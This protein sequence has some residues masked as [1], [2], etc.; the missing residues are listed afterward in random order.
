MP[1]TYPTL[2]FLE[3]KILWSLAAWRNV[4]MG[5][6]LKVF[7]ISAFF[8]A[9]MGV[10]QPY[11]AEWYES[12]ESSGIDQSRSVWKNIS[13]SGS[14]TGSQNVQ[15]AV[16]EI[17]ESVSREAAQIAE[18]AS[19]MEQD[20]FHATESKGVTATASAGDGGCETQVTPS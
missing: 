8:F 14:V 20:A 3:A 4:A 11:A 18:S 10:I 19:A 16:A 1:L 12:M 9:S 7:I 17:S 13:T 6:L 15:Q 5:K 2:L